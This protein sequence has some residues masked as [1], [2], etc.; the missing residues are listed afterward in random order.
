MLNETL[1]GD[2]Y[3][4]NVNVLNRYLLLKL[5]CLLFV[6]AENVELSWKSHELLIK[7]NKNGVVRFDKTNGVS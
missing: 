6:E 3:D 2:K 5:D 4:D 7:E 1:L